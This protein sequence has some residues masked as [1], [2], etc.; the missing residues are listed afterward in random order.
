MNLVTASRHRFLR[1]MSGAAT[2]ALALSLAAVYSPPTAN[3]AVE[4]V[5]SKAVAA[6]IAPHDIRKAA[7]LSLFRPGNIISNAVFF[8]SSTMNESQI[9][10]FLNQRV[11][12][13][14]TGATCL[15]NFT[16]TTTTRPSDSYCSGYSGATS[17]TAARIIMKVA[18]SC[19]MNPQVLLVMLEKEQSLVTHTDPSAFRFRAAMGQGCPDTAGCDVRYYGFMNQ[20]YGAA[21]Q[22]RIYTE[23]RYFTY[24][25]PGKT[26]NIRFNPTAACGSS[27]VY[28]ENQATAN[29]YYYTPYQ[30]NAS[31][32]RAGY[33]VGDNC[34]AYG[35]RNFFHFFN[36]WFGSTQDRVSVIVQGQ[37]RGEVYLV[38][39]G[40]KHH[41]RSYE[42]LMVFTSRLG[43]ISSVPPRYVDELPS[44][45]PVS[46]YIHDTR[47]GT[48]VLLEGDGTRHRFVSTEQIATFGYSFA[49]YV[50]LEPRLIDA[51]TSGP[52]V[53][54]FIRAGA[55][56]EVYALE[57]G[58][59]RHVF[60]GLA[61]RAASTGTE[62][63]VATM[64]VTAAS[65]IALG[66]TYFAPNTL[67]RG[68]TS[69][70]VMLTTPTSTLVHIPSFDLAKEFGAT[71]YSVVPDEALSRHSRAG[72]KLAP[73]ITCGATTFIGAGG[74]RH[75]VSGIDLGGLAATAITPAD[76]DA[77][78][79]ATTGGVSSP[80]FLQPV[81]RGDVYV[82]EAGKLRHVRA[83]SQLMILNGN[84]PLTI[85]R[86]SPGT[87]EWLGVAAPLF[88]DGTL[89]Q[90]AGTPDVYRS[91]LS[92][93]HHVQSMKTLLALG[94]GSLPSIE[95]RPAN[96]LQ[97]YEVGDPLP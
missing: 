65:K 43:G 67:V 87:V 37:G 75:A 44:G 15:K 40:A 41:I 60:D 29:L 82:L 42:D 76:C 9:T 78:P 14:A 53:G 79:R 21:R 52:D 85:L 35:N 51:F 58:A 97:A 28:I 10:T 74:Y 12:R 86:W 16:Q 81:G 89:V 91:T 92:Q 45:L 7:N 23:N 55:Q 27:P 47:T 62:G 80:F 84:R 90:F 8:D 77:I 5:S 38:S 20:V 83:Y 54:R 25:A 96:E 22:M 64:D 61:W 68:A 26:W 49:S 69:N 57:S 18:Q 56:P 13:C 1:L 63:Y 3:A 95:A 93:L 94:N 4:P 31:A 59:R 46:R 36:D 24:Y 66:A 2:L 33:G 70:D 6:D 73:F 39:N 19:G 11:P 50:N 32:L 48:L 34:G 17:E 72:T 30:P 88:A 71:H